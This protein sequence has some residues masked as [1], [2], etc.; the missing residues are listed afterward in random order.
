MNLPTCC[1]DLELS[2]DELLFPEQLDAQG[3]YFLNVHGLDQMTLGELQASMV[4]SGERRV[5]I[6]HRCA[7]LTDEGCCSIYER[8]PLVCRMFDCKTR[9]DCACNGSGSLCNSR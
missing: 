1:T 3:R 9:S 5:R 6:A 4:V 8:R 2:V 7:K